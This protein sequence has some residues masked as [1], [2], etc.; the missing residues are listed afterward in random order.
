MLE[1]RKI[2]EQFNNELR[3]MV[4]NLYNL[5]EVSMLIIQD[6]SKKIKF[7]EHISISKMLHVI[8]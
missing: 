8:G 6:I 7:E 4:L 2:S 1:I 5:E 3:D